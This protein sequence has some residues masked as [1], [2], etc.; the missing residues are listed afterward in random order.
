MSLAESCTPA[1]NA[2]LEYQHQNG[3]RGSESGQDGRRILVNQNADN[4][5]DSDSDGYQVNHLVNTFERTVFQRL[6]LA[7]NLIQ[8]VQKTFN[9][10]E[11]GDD[12]ANQTDLQ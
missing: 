12:E 1:T 6:V 5:Y 2:V 11:S 3:G 10:H 8:R 7:G 4:Q 9:Q